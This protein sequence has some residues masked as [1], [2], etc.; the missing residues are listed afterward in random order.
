MGG[1][2]CQF[3][4]RLTPQYPNPP[5]LKLISIAKSHSV[6]LERFPK[7]AALFT[8]GFNFYILEPHTPQSITEISGEAIR[9]K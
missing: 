5:I 8:W 7:S 9:I 3:P 1:D 2:P 4:A 6:L